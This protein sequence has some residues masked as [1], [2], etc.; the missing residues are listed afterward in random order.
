M[1]L[2][3]RIIDELT[4]GNVKVNA[5]ELVICNVLLIVGGMVLGYGLASFANFALGFA[6]SISGGVMLFAGIFMTIRTLSVVVSATTN[7]TNSAK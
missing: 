7:A 3:W 2:H 5:S 6:L 4:N 1:F